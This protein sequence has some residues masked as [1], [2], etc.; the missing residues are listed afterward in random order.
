MA[1][2]Q[3]QLGLRQLAVDD[4]QVGPAYAAG[5][6][7]DQELAVAWLG[8]GHIR[9]RKRAAV[10]DDGAPLP[11]R[12]SEQPEQRAIDLVRALLLEPVTRALDHLY[13]QVD[14]AARHRV[15]RH[16]LH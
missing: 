2:D 5:G 13:A 8:L 10:E 16:P 14:D 4:V 12:L 3:R 15:G 9:W 11:V 6:D 1:D 7:L